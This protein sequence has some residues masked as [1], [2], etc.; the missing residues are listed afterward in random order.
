M[1]AFKCSQSRVDQ[2]I[3]KFLLSNEV[4]DLTG[5]GKYRI[6][7]VLRLGVGEALLFDILALEY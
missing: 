3:V 2:I 5:R 1:K 6:Y 4:G 7:G